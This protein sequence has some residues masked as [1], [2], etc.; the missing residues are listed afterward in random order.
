MTRIKQNKIFLGLTRSLTYKSSRHSNIFLLL[1]VRGSCNTLLFDMTN[2]IEKL[3]L[4]FYAR[5][6]GFNWQINPEAPLCPQ[7]IINKETV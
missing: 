6:P 2:F 5:R 1:K 3:G 7:L 4:I